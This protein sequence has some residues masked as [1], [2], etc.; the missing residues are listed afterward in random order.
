MLDGPSVSTILRNM[1]WHG[2]LLW[3]NLTL[4]PADTSLDECIRPCFKVQSMQMAHISTVTARL[5]ERVCW[6]SW[7]IVVEFHSVTREPGSTKWI[8]LPD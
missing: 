5:V 8:Y 7:V 4:K 2:S 3:R 1:N 6:S